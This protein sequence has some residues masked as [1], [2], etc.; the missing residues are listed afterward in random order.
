MIKEQESDIVLVVDDSPEALGLLNE[1]LENA[2]YTVLIALEGKQAI[3]ITNKITPDI[4]L[5]D[6]IMPNMDGFET[7]KA[8]KANKQL[9]K[10]PIIFMTGLS[11]TDSIIKGLEAGGVDYLHKPIKPDE[12]IARMKVHLNNARLTGSAQSALDS[13]GQQLFSINNQGEV[14]WATPLTQELF[15]LAQIDQAWRDK[16]LNSQL[17]HWLRHN[18]AI[19]H[20][21]TLENTSHPLKVRLVDDAQ[22]N[23]IL[24]KLI[25]LQGPS[26]TEN[27][28]KNLQTTERES[29]VLYWIAKGKT[30]KE[31][32]E[33]LS[34]SPRTVNKHLEQIYKKLKVE[35]RTAAA[36]VAI[37]ILSS[38]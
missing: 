30:N 18:P 5:L 36:A 28:Q 29:D 12:L 33:I 11:D 38:D 35:N 10:I 32:G 24:L 9:A 14:L 23:E 37:K 21:V 4:I 26:E 8:I 3:T 22:P 27:L 1:A 20:T 7:C 31:I 13:T 15:E 19:G 6:A 2:G 34:M 16:H 17:K 25:N